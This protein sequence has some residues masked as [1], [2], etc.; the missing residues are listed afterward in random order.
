MVTFLS[1]ASVLEFFLLAGNTPR[2]VQK[3]LATVTGKA[4]LP[5]YYTLGFHYSKWEEI[6]T[7]RL[8]DINSRFNA[9]DV[10]YD[11][12]WLDI[13]YTDKNKYFELS[14]DKFENFTNFTDQME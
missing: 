1:E 13:G 2:Q 11:T 6:N 8:L 4:P 12:L 7:Q 14:V 5:P 3:S 9:M 10:P